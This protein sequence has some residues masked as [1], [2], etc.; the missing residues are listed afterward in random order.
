LQTIG[1]VGKKVP[2]GYIAITMVMVF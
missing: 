2:I 1:I